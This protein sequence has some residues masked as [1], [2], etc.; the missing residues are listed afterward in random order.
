MVQ[1]KDSTV[2]RRQ[3]SAI[4][5]FPQLI[6]NPFSPRTFHVRVLFSEGGLETI[7]LFL[8]GK[9]FLLFLSFHNCCRNCKRNNDRHRP[10]RSSSKDIL[11]FSCQRDL[12][13][14]SCLF[15]GTCFSSTPHSDMKYF[16]PLFHPAEFCSHS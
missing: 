10:C 6:S 4:A 7:F 9:S 2:S 1:R 16:F 11:S 5:H 8:D 12:H 15:L 13:T 14:K 3:V